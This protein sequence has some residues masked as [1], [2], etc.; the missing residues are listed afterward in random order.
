M[1]AHVAIE[2][3]ESQPQGCTAVSRAIDWIQNYIDENPYTD[4]AKEARSIIFGLQAV[5]QRPGLDELLALVGQIAKSDLG[6]EEISR[7]KIRMSQSERTTGEEIKSNAIGTDWPGN[8]AV[9]TLGK[10]TATY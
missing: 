8:A 7:A 10:R 5:R 1:K 4:A 3:G 9:S 6:L 2:N